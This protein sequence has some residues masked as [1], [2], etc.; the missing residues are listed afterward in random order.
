MT[1]PL[2]LVTGSAGRIGRAV[3]KELTTRGHRVRGLDRL[4]TPGLADAMVGSI[5]DASTCAL[6]AA[7]VHTLIHLA[8]TPDDV[9][10]VV[11]DLVPN[12]V[13][14]VYRIFEAA[15]LAG[16]KRMVLASSGQVV[17]GQRKSGLLPVGADVQPTPRYWY[18]ATKMFLE[19]A[20]RAYAD[21]HGISVLVV[22][23]GWCPRPGQ[24]QEIAAE[25]WAQDVYLS[26][27]DAGR[28]FACAVESP[29]PIH[30]AV[31]YATS[32]AV[33]NYPYDLEPAR[34]LLGYVPQEMWPQGVE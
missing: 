30:F 14:G 23:L 6:A 33:R 18:A 28:F 27:N 17:W 16:V 4:P 1:Q 20:G 19:A 11:G 34:T 22:R 5:T 26:P 10:D 8:A 21:T 7:D 25:A 13:I 31:V 2:V 12:N 15:R 24:E 29:A 3:V 9:E 32:K